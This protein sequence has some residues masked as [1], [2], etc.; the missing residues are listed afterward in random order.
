MPIDRPFAAS[1]IIFFFKIGADG[2]GKID[3]VCIVG[4]NQA[5]E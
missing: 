5:D 3:G 4:M 1:E 2:F